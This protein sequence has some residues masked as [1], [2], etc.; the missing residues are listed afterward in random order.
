MSQFQAVEFPWRQLPA[1]LNVWNYTHWEAFIAEKSDPRVAAWPLMHSIVPTAL[2]CAAYLAFVVVGKRVMR[3]REPFN[4]KLVMIG[5]NLV[6]IPLNFWLFYRLIQEMK[7][8]DFA[9]TCNKVDYSEGGTDLAWLVYIY[10]L[11]KLLDFCDTIFMILRNKPEQ[12]S[13]LHVY[14]H[15]MM[16]FIWWMAVKWA[17]GGDGIIGPLMN[18]FIH[19]VMYSYYLATSLHVFIPGKRYITQLQMAQLLVLLVSSVVTVA[20]DCDYP[21]WT[22]YGQMAFLVTLLFLFSAF[23]AKAYRRRSM[24]GA[25]SPAKDK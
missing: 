7:K 22:Q 17:A 1:D 9:L 10:Y 5:Y 19:G 16:F 4:L 23:Y 8:M 2:M 14:H 21:H 24:S 13:F 11:S 6:V 20:F 15:G 25:A 12:A 18:T 3:G